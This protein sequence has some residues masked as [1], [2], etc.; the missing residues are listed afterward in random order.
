LKRGRSR[1]RLAWRTMLERN[2][3]HWLEGRDRLQERILWTLFLLITIGFALTQISS[4][5]GPSDGLVITW[6]WWAHCVLCLWIALQAPRRLADDKQSGALELILCTPLGSRDIIRG[7]MQAFQR[8]YGRVF[9]G[10]LAL[11][12]FLVFAHFSHNG[13]WRAFRENDLFQLSLCGLFIFPLQA[14]SVARLG[15]YHGLLHANSVRA[16]FVSIWKVGLL[17]WILFFVFVLACDMASSRFKNLRLTET[18]V[19]SLWAA[20]HLIPCLLFLFQANWFLKYRFRLLALTSS[21]RPWWK[22]FRRASSL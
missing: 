7:N 17:P 21:R 14:Y 3:I 6:A 22:W 5:A 18:L 2:P 19:F 10:L 4:N 1:T 20:C 11:D 8:R 15:L 16:S 12:G 9:L 13:G